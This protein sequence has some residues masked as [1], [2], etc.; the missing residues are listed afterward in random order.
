MDE[1]KC[2][3]NG[4]VIPCLEQKGTFGRCRMSG[5]TREIARYAEVI[6]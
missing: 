2:C 6:V 5:L 1:A 3:K 4:T